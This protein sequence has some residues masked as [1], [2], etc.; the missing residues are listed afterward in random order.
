M[1][2]QDQIDQARKIDL[3][4][5]ARRYTTLKHVA[6]TGG[7]EYAGPC[8]L[9]G[10][11]DRFHVQPST[12]R[13]FC[14]HCTGGPEQDGWKDAIDLQ[15]RLTGASFTQA[16]QSLTGN[17]G[18]HGVRPYPADATS[19]THGVHLPSSD[20][21]SDQWQKRSQT[22]VEKAQEA[23]WGKAGSVAI[24]WQE[25][26]PLNGEPRLRHLSPRDWL[27]ERGL[28]PETLQAAHIGYVPM[29]WRDNPA[30]WGLPGQAVFIPQGIL[31]PS[32][33]QDELWSLKIRRPAGKPK[34]TQVRGGRPALYLADTL[35]PAPEAVCITE[36]EFDA[37]LLRQCLLHASNPR[38]RSL[39]VITLGSNSNYPTLERWARYLYPVKYF[40]LL[41]DQDGKSDS[42][43][44]FW[45]GL[46]ARTRQVKWRNLRP[47]DKDLT[48]YHRSGGRLLDLVS[49][50]ITQIGSGVRGEAESFASPALPETRF[51]PLFDPSPEPSLYPP[52]LDPALIS[53]PGSH[54][55][56]S[57]PQPAPELREEIMTIEAMAA[58]LRSNGLRIKSFDWPAGALRPRVE[59]EKRA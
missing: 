23:L 59:L 41:Y 56:P 57:L 20:P 26:D 22:L 6:A 52:A 15:M 48:D 31:I 58:Y 11:Y 53:A 32:N 3:L 19:N 34:Y 37:L 24:Q 30:S 49:W 2:S 45:Q 5:L 54:Q 29:N 28:E 51:V 40:L 38:W 36:G 18:A 44:R 9:C 14:R 35:L 7:G 25:I 16:V 42:A 27:A 13:W 12:N 43:V 8:P 21:P 46:S 55:S 39:G 10:G 33:V 4:S 1:L 47:G 17:V 50:A